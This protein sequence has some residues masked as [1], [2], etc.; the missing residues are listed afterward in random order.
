[1]KDTPDEITK[2]NGLVDAYEKTTDSILICKP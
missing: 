2:S 1:M